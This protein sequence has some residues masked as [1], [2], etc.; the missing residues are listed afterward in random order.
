MS[1]RKENTKEKEKGI[2]NLGRNP[3]LRPN[4]PY[5]CP[6]RA[7]QVNHTTRARAGFLVTVSGTHVASRPRVRVGVVHAVSQTSGPVPPNATSLTWSRLHGGPPRQG[8]LPSICVL[9]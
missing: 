4:Y 9:G 3:S 1:K 6:H 8:C 5:L 7:A 2:Q